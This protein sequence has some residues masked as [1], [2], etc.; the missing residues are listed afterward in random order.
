MQFDYPYA[1]PRPDVR[2][3]LEALGDYLHNRHGIRIE[4][5]DTERAR[6]SGRYLTVKIDGHMTIDDGVIFVRGE[7]PGLLWRK[8]AIKYLQG[9]LAKY[10]DP[11]TPLEQLPRGKKSRNKE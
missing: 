5:L 8:K 2:G 9:K 10:L 3:R 1:V 7:D 11:S 4:W 6:F